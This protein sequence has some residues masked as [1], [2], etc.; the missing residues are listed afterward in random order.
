M[1]V[2]AFEFISIC[3]KRELAGQ[4]M[5][6]KNKATAWDPQRFLRHGACQ[7]IGEIAIQKGFDPLVNGAAM[8]VQQPRLFTEVRD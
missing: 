1:Q 3:R 4:S 5:S 7:H 6:I 2:F 8:V